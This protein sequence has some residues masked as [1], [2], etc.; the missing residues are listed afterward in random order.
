MQCLNQNQIFVAMTP[1]MAIHPQQLNN[2]PSEIHP[3][4]LQPAVRPNQMGAVY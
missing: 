3:Q 1:N 2:F 4:T